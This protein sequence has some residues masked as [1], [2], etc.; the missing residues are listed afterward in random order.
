[1]QIRQQK[2]LVELL[3]GGD[4]WMRDIVMHFSKIIDYL[5]KVNNYNKLDVNIENAIKEQ[6]ENLDDLEAILSEFERYSLQL[7]SCEPIDSDKTLDKL[8]KIHKYTTD[9]QWHISE[10]NEMNGEVIKI[11]S[12]K[13]E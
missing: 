4:V 1:M 6:K 13:R 3:K 7:E 10:I 2:L 8:M 12:A 9:L 5:E 11:C